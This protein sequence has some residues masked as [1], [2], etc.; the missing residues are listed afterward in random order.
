MFGKIE[1]KKKKYS[2]WPDEFSASADFVCPDDGFVVELKMQEIPEEVGEYALLDTGWLEVRYAVKPSRVKSGFSKCQLNDG[3]TKFSRH[4]KVA[5]I[6]AQLEFVSGQFGN[7][8]IVVDAPCALLDTS[9]PFYLVYD[10]VRLAWVQD[11]IVN[12]DYPY[13]KVYM[14]VFRQK[15]DASLVA[16]RF[17]DMGAVSVTEERCEA[18]KNLAYYCPDGYN[19]W[20]GDASVFE[21][22]GTYHVLYLED[23]HN[24]ASRFET[25]AHS[26]RHLTTRDFVNW[27]DCGDILEINE[28]WKTAGTGTMLF[29]NG[30]YYYVHGFH[31]SR[32]VPE[33]ETGTQIFIERGHEQVNTPIPYAEIKERGYLPCGANYMVSDDGINFVPGDYQLHVAEN[34]CVYVD[35]KGGLTMMAG[36]GANGEWHADDIL[37]TWTKKNDFSM[38]ESPLSPSTECPFLLEANGYRY[39]V[40]GRTGFWFAKDGEPWQDA[41]K[42]G[43]DVY[44]GLFV[45]SFC[46]TDDGRLL[47]C[48]W[49]GGHGWAYL[50]MH[51]ELIQRPDGRLDMRWLPE[52]APNAS[53]L[54]PYEGEMNG[55]DSYYVEIDVRA[56]TDGI[57]NVQFDGTERA[58]I[59]LATV[60]KRVQ[61]NK[62][63]KG[64]THGLPIFPAYVRARVHGKLEDTTDTHLDA[65]N[66]S[67]GEVDCITGDYT[68]RVMLYREPKRK[69][70][71]MDCEFAGKRTM[72]S[73]RGRARYKT[74]KVSVE[75][76]AEVKSIRKFRLKKEFGRVGK[77]I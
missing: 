1:L 36:Y 3:I 37:S 31:T 39:L 44:D 40:N 58:E 70:L 68:V 2:F 32:V 49:L 45:P 60:D 46:R 41:G 63:E 23:R 6:E 71:I 72:V 52:L 21:H 16:V 20:A 56:G 17:G 8:Q 53:E 5:L 13:G 74:V 10:G 51:R 57:V 47:L 34:P 15:S 43:I 27:T 7:K 11:E 50:L 35:P 48:G 67:I 65:R 54:E 28:Q 29:W 55:S 77:R 73:N 12:C 25:G 19:V 18:V 59:S 24:H 4:G 69:S 64:K 33:S 61:I 14:P 22:D 76:D 9:K 42:H 26:V 66:F 30:K 62:V 75:G 38:S